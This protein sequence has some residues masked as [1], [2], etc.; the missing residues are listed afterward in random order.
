[1]AKESTEKKVR[2]IIKTFLF[3]H[4]GKKFTSTQIAQFVNTNPLGLGKYN[5][6]SVTVTRWSKDKYKYFFRDVKMER[7]N[8]RNVWYFWV[9]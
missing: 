3:A 8:E 6:T 5:T 1:M 2:L 9:E 4:K 7:A